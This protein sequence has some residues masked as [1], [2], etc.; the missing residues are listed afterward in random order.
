MS[1]QAAE[2]RYRQLRRLAFADAT[3]LLTEV[4]I[5]VP[6]QLELREVAL[7]ALLD[8]LAKWES[9]P[10]RPVAW[11]WR[12]LLLHYRQNHSARFDLAVFANGLLSAIALG[13]PSKTRA[14]CALDFVEASPDPCHALKGRVL[15]VVLTALERYCV[16]IGAPEMRLTE[17]LPALIGLYTGKY[18]FTVAM[19]P[20]GRP[21]C[22]REVTP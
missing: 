20:G 6:G 2:E 8:S 22:S 1:R 11:D 17:P 9:Y 21:Y 15:P 4:A 3:R 10:R 14:H 12:K 13:K 5:A 18:G 7:P 19:G 16:A